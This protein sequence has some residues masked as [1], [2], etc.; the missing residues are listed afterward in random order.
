MAAIMGINLLNQL[1]ALM[2]L[3]GADYLAVFDANQLQALALLFLG[4]FEY[5]YDIALVFFG[6]HLLVLGYLVYRSGCFPR[7]LGVLLVV[8]SLSYLSDSFSGFLFPDARR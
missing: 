1:T 4:A 2:L 6:L 8:T 3:S 7:V 5:G